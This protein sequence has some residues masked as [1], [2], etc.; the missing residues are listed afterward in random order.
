MVNKLRMIAGIVFIIAL[1]VAA[2][3]AIAAQV[4]IQYT[5]HIKPMIFCL[6]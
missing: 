3:S 5:N 1:N 6:P 2:A 4:N